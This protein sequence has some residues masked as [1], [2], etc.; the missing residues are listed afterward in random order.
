MELNFKSIIF[1]VF[2]SLTLYWVYRILDW[3]WFKPKKLEKCLREQGFKGNP[4]RLF[5]GDQYDSGKL[6]RQ[7]LTKPIGVEEDVK[8]R[9]V[10]HILKTVGTHGMYLTN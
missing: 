3:V 8:K 2:V 5:L 6:I 9:I 7:A 4:Y 1:L 10:P